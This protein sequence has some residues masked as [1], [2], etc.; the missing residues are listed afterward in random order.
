MRLRDGPLV[1]VAENHWASI[2]EVQKVWLNDMQL[3]RTWIKHSE[4]EHGGMLKFEM[5]ARPP[6]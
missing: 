4:T 3:D 5:R 1:I 2:H 6:K